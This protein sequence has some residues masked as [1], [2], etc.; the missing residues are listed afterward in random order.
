M[1]YSSP[2]RLAAGVSLFLLGACASAN[3]Q[4]VDYHLIKTIALPAAPGGSEYFDYITV[5][6]DARR[7][8]VSHGTEVDVLNADDYSLIGRIGGLQRCHGVVVIKDRH[9]SIWKSEPTALFELVPLGTLGDG[10]RY[11]LASYEVPSQ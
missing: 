7:V 1:R 11:A 10:V 6:A 3:A 8:Y 4:A 2:R 5:D 9:I